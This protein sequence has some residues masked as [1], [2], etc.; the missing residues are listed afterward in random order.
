MMLSIA[1]V[2]VNPASDGIAGSPSQTAILLTEEE[3]VYN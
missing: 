1:L 2:P 3:K